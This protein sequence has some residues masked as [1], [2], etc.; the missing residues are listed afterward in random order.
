[1]A[2]PFSILVGTVGL[3][4][5]CFRVGKYLHDVKEGADKVDEE[6]E[7]LSHQIEAIKSVNESIKSVF[8]DD[9]VHA[10]ETVPKRVDGIQS[11]WEEIGEKVKSCHDTLVKLFALIKLIVGKESPKILSKLDGLRK[12]LRKQSKE[13]E[14]CTLRQQLRDYHHS[15]Q[16]LLTSVNM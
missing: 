15:L 11:L 16:T 4:D 5:V 1:M 14:F 8:E 9:L 7:V 6:I 13:E 12:Y 2:D 3:L 10:T